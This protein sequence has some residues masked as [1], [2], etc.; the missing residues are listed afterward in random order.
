MG[1]ASFVSFWSR[2]TV[3]AAAHV[4]E[5]TR[6]REQTRAAARFE[7]TALATTTNQSR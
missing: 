2:I 3:A 7:E 1:C 4:N 6:Y 5:I